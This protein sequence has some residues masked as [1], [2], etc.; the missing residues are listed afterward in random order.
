MKHSTILLLAIA[1]SLAV[2][3]QAVAHRSHYSGA[4]NSGETPA[5]FGT[6]AKLALLWHWS[7]GEIRSVGVSKVTRSDRGVICITPKVALD[8]NNIYPIVS[9]SPEESNT[10]AGFAG[11]RNQAELCKGDKDI[12]VD[13]YQSNGKSAS[14]SDNV[15]FYL[16]VE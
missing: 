6:N 2:S 10:L 5:G 9:F 11:S 3:G 15:G 12:E 16:I 8:A 1:S 4:E 14:P 13:T 7:E